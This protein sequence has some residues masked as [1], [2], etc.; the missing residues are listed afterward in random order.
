MTDEL[1]WLTSGDGDSAE[2]PTLLAEIHATVELERA[3]AALGES[4]SRADAAVDEPLLGAR[5]VGLEAGVVL[6]EPSTEG[7][8]AATLARHGESPAGRYLGVPFALDDIARRAAAAGV[9]LS[10][11]ARGPFGPEVLVLG[12]PVSGPHTLVVER[13]TVPS[14]R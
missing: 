10:R 5:V 3:L 8:L 12:G 4:A 9:S 2:D 13:R 6:A 1:D 14:R 11:P 7:R